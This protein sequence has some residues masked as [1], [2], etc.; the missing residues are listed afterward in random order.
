[1]VLCQGIAKGIWKHETKRQMLKLE[2]NAFSKFT[3]A[4]Q[5]EIKEEAELLRSFFEVKTL[6]LTLSSL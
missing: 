3:T 6:D 5:S 2:I 1:M 4:E